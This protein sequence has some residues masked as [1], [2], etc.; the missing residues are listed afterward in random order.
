[1]NTNL[2]RRTALKGIGMATIGAGAMNPFSASADDKKD[3][4]GL[5][6]VKI[7]KVKAIATCPD[8]IELVTVKV[9]TSE[10]GLYGLGCATFRQ[11]AHAV[12]AA[13]DKYLNDFCIGK[14]VDNI[15]DLWQSTYQSSYWR[16]GP[17][18]NNA[19]SGLDQALWD[20]KGK[21]ANMPVY[22]LLGGKC[23]F[24]VDCYA[25][26]SGNSPEKVA[27]DVARYIEEGFRHVR[28]QMGGYGSTGITDSPD[29]KDAGFG[30]P[31]DN[32]MDPFVYY[33][34]TIKILR[35]PGKGVE[36]GLNCSTIC[37]KGCSQWMQ[38]ILSKDWRSIVRFL[39]KIHFHLKITDISNS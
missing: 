25:H 26:A 19:L 34:S 15:E 39:L 23:R 8:G 16:N 28:I 35:R 38:L 37:M 33:Q 5:P 29:F 36:K 21:R 4:K 7:T 11:R 31:R 2:N 1:M 24:A 30:M 20:I 10:S 18:L 9:E 12:V 27:D 14:D 32:F 3:Y 6:P 13:I 22:Q 17:V